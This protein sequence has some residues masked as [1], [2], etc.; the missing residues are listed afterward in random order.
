MNDS[1]VKG[2]YYSAKY[3]EQGNI[4]SNSLGNLYSSNFVALAVQTKLYL[5]Q[6]KYMQ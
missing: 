4:D 3:L 5:N 6:I 1:L 2:Q